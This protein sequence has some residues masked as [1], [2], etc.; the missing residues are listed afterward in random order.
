MF[1]FKF[2]HSTIKLRKEKKS[3]FWNT[4]LENYR[5]VI[6]VKHIIGI[7]HKMIKTMTFELCMLDLNQ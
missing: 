2:L 1:R 6:Y 7:A 5:L 4:K 3:T